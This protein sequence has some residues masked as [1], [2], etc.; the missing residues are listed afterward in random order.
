M[1]S[2][3]MMTVRR[4]I[5][6]LKKMPPDAKVAICAHDQDPERGEFDGF[7]NRVEASPKAI[8]ERGAGVV[9]LL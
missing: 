5:K 3:T 8:R 7:V 6:A 1:A 4:L 2:A 9:I